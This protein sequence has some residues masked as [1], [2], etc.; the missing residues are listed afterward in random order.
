MI[1]ANSPLNIDDGPNG[2]LFYSSQSDQPEN[3]TA[4]SL[5]QAG[6]P[7]VHGQA[8]LLGR[9][10]D[11]SGTAKPTSIL[12]ES[13]IKVKR[14]CHETVRQ[15]LPKRPLSA[16]QFFQSHYSDEVRER[17]KTNPEIQ[18]PKNL[19]DWGPQT[20]A[21]WKALSKE[22]KAPFEE[23]ARESSEQYKTEKKKFD[24]VFCNPPLRARHAYNCFMAAHGSKTADGRG[25]VCKKELIERWRALNDAEKAPYLQEAKLDA[26][27]H[28]RES[29]EYRKWCTENGQDYDELI[30]KKKK[31]PVVTK[32]GVDAKVEKKPRNSTKKKNA[33]G[34][35]KRTRTAVSEAKKPTIKKKGATKKRPPI[36]K[37]TTRKR[38]KQAE[39]VIEDEIDE[40]KSETETYAD[41]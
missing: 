35:K 33:P 26:E 21:A 17:A 9:A 7:A 23:R 14:L 34:A 22:E 25:G 32:G 37:A 27:R 15:F 5:L 1:G 4:K 20:M 29:E 2:L 30:R 3:P 8:I 40:A 6:K 38:P 16:Y 31:I 18:K 41:D 39:P 19:V 36:Q 10:L 12:K 24:S 11:K 28:L 13:A